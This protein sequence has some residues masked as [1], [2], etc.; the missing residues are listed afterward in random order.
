MSVHRVTPVRPVRGPGHAFRIPTTGLRALL[1]AGIGIALVVPGPAGA[2]PGGAAR[3]SSRSLAALDAAVEREEISY[4]AAGREKLLFLFERD[5]LDPRFSLDGDRPAR[6]ATLVLDDLGRNLDRLDDEA[7]VLYDR[8]VGS[9]GPARAGAGSD[10]GIQILLVHQTSHFYIEYNTSGTHAV[11]LADVAPANGVP[12]FVEAAGEAME[13]SWQTG[14]ITLGYNAPPASSATLYNGKYL[15]QFQAQAAYGFTSVLSGTRTRIVLHNNYIGFP[16]NDDPDGAVLGALRATCAHEFKHAIQR[17]YSLWSEGGWLEL[18]AT[19]MEDI[20]YDNVNDYYNY[21]GGAGSPF[22]EPQTPLDM[23][24]F[25]STGSYEDCNW[26][27]YQSEHLGLAHMRDF[28]IRRQNNPG[29]PVMFSYDQ[30]L[31]LSGSTLPD[32]WGEYVTWNFASGARAGGNG[33]GYGEAVDY[34]TVPV[35]S[36]HGSLPV[37]TTVGSVAH[38][39]ANIRLI[40]NPDGALTGQPEFTFTGAGGVSWRVSVLLKDLAGNVTRIPLPLTGGA[41]TLLVPGQDYANVAY[42]A[43]VIGNPTVSG[44]A[45]SYSFSA[46]AVA[47]IFVEH[48][49]VWDT[50]ETIAPYTIRARILPGTGT[51]NPASVTLAYRV[52]G[53]ELATLLMT[54]TGSPDEY[55]ALIPAQDVGARVEYR[56]EAQSTLGDPASAPGLAGAFHAYDVVT[57]F[58]PFESAGAWTVGA[59]GDAATSGLWQ[60]A[61]P[62]GTIAQPGEDFTIPPGTTCFVTANGTPGG[63][64]GEA[65]VDGGRT[66]LVSPVFDLSTGGPYASVNV[67]FRRWYS[68]GLGAS[69]DDVWRIEVSNDGGTAWQTLETMSSG[70]E[71]WQL[72]EDDLLARFGTVNALRFR[73][74]AEDQGAGSLIEA[75]LDDFV[76]IAV[77]QS[78]VAVPGN[79]RAGAFALSA[80]R[81]SPARGTVSFALD[82]PQAALLS[83]RIHDAAGRV[84]RVL[85]QGTIH[86]AGAHRLVWDGRDGAGRSSGSGMYFLEV[87]TGAAREHRR[88]VRVQ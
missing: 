74:L 78:A 29:E 71:E 68:N 21:I 83:A 19:W 49:R 43:L 84:V 36:A 18:D 9:T 6:C 48:Q 23:D 16:P 33:Y 15:I 56:I 75:G 54:P 38:L 62:L 2:E 86:A 44:A 10:P 41:G 58:E 50:I 81:P 35:T 47:P 69:V 42:A 5:R 59:A 27:H 67:R 1:G 39:A 26:Q 37:L 76:L 30:T 31:Q 85:A 70:A 53:G 7:R 82:L 3:G 60:R 66:T 32:A 64:A 12:D 11:P 51:P 14:V 88:F 28:W 77:P 63:A 40:A 34:P 79:A 72:I 46:R 80:A 24:A 45:A 13:Q 57:V 65:D 87:R 4:A 52:N 22:T 17:T 73:F 25:G 20:V 55:E 61:V 8:H